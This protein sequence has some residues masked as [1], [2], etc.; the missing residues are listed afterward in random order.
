[1]PVSVSVPARL[2]RLQHDH[3]LH[4]TDISGPPRHGEASGI[5]ELGNGIHLPLPN[6]QSRSPTDPENTR[7]IGK[8]T[9][10]QIEAILTAIE[11][12][13]GV[14]TNFDRHPVDV[15]RRHVGEVCDDQIPRRL[16]RGGEIT[17]KKTDRDSEAIA[18]ASR[19]R[20]R[21]ARPVDSRYPPPG[22]FGG[23]GQ[24]DAAGPGTDVEHSRL[25]MQG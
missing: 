13:L 1:V 4:T 9:A 19:N 8:Q 25:V 20:Q 12:R 21:F 18:V 7:Q 22:A 11:G 24:G 14:V 2:P 23:Q 3:P 17:T 10:H 16:D 6:F 15:I 5:C